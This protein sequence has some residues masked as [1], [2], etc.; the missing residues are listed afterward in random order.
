MHMVYYYL[1]FND[2]YKLNFTACIKPRAPTIDNSPCIK[3]ENM[4]ES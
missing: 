1:S 3:A 4:H 2:N